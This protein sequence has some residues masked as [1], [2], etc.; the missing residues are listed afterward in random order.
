L[1]DLKWTVNPKASKFQ[2]QDPTGKLMM[3]PSDIVLLEDPDFKQYV[4]I[5]A[6]DQKKF[7]AD[8]ADAFGRLLALGT[9]N[10]YD[11]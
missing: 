3:L 5:Y 6:K 9:S 2:F 11:V 7:F 8:F 1:K 4:D 10:L